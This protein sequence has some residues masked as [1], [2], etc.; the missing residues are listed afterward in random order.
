[1]I[2]LLPFATTE[3]QRTKNVTQ[4]TVHR[5]RETFFSDCFYQQ[6]DVNEC[7]TN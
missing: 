7:V 4:N 1:L 5:H 2:E 6:C 3:K